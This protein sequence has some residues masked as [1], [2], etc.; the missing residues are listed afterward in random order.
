M[1][2]LFNQ[3]KDLLQN[4]SGGQCNQGGQYDQNQGNQSQGGQYDQ[5][6]QQQGNNQQQSG[7]QGGGYNSEINNGKF[8]YRKALMVIF[9]S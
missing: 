8:L 7:N 9:R 6:L 2:N 1:D 5:N 4:Q 3:A